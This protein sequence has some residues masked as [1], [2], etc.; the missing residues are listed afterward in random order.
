MNR[1]LMASIHIASMY[2]IY[3]YIQASDKVVPVLGKKCCALGKCVSQK[4]CL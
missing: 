2:G 1:R 4:S 3:V